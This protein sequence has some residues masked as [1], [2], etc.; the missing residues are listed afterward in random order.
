MLT[1]FQE[2]GFPMFFLLA[3]GLAALVVAV[4]YARVPG[5]ARL[6]QTV[7]LSFATGFTAITGTAK[8][9]ATVGHQVPAFLAR[10]REMTLKPE[11]LLEG[12]AESMAPLILGGTL[13]SLV[14]LIVTVGLYRE[15]V[16]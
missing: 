1:F 2:G 9:I 15:P 12:L 14:A 10:H 5:R 13:L 16:A 11:V 6:R 3:F 4:L 8:D 7:A